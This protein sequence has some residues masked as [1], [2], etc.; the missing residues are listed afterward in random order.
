MRGSPSFL[1]VAAAVVVAGA[2]VRSQD[3]PRFR[4]GVELVHVTATVT[5]GSGHFV[6]GLGREDFTVSEDGVP[7]QV[8]SFSSDRVPVSLGIILDASGSMS[9][10]KLG[11]ARAAI[12][13]LIV[14]LLGPDDELF[15]LEFADTAQLTQEWTRDRR[16]ISEAV[17]AVRSVGGTA[18]YDAV[19]AALPVAGRGVHRKKALLLISDGNDTDSHL[20]VDELVRRIRASDVLVYALGI[21]SDDELRARGPS[22]PQV[23][24]PG[25]PPPFPGGRRPGRPPFPPAPPT[26][27]TPPTVPGDTWR[28]PDD[29]VDADA[30]RRIT[31][32]TGGRTEILRRVDD[33]DEATARLADELS[34]Q[35][36]LGYVSPAGRDGQWHGISVTV[37]DGRLTVRARQGYIAS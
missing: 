27:P 34:R 8:T 11:A 15:F 31:D 26:F 12:D 10:D 29:R 7:Q 1:V 18:M 28:R 13:R 9:R 36:S 33:L 3:A 6:T 23:R 17:G 16:A 22:R 21:D 37:R 24:F 4:G 30:L 19:A 25:L 20:E 5:D 2:A 32:D 14:D 35:Y